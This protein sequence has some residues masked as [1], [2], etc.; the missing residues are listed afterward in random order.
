MVSFLYISFLFRKV[1][2]GVLAITKLRVPP[3]NNRWRVGGD[4]FL[5]LVFAATCREMALQS[6]LFKFE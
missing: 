4:S 1:Y 3:L 2:A 5:V 6:V